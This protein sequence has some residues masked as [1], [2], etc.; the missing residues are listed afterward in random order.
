MS[1]C[2]LILS[3]EGDEKTKWRQETW[4][5]ENIQP[6]R[7]VQDDRNSLPMEGGGVA[8]YSR[9]RM[10]LILITSAIYT[11]R[12][13]TDKWV[14]TVPKVASIEFRSIHIKLD[15]F[16]CEYLFWMKSEKNFQFFQF[17]YVQHYYIFCNWA[18]FNLFLYTECHH[19][20]LSALYI[21]QIL[22]TER[23]KKRSVKYFP[24]PH[25][26]ATKFSI[27]FLQKKIITVKINKILNIYL[28]YAL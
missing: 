12:T 5:W 24:I 14:T 15:R 25:C 2:Q 19:K 28:V 26:L 3:W 22:H 7:F 27:M 6:N 23:M 1:V 4:V 17:V 9:C 20:N 18:R 11:P 13:E 8:H 10:L 21:I 16:N